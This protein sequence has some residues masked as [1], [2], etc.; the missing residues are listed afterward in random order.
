MRQNE[1]KKCDIDAV[2]EQLWAVHSGANGA[3]DRTTNTFD[4]TLCLFMILTS[5]PKFGLLCWNDFQI[6]FIT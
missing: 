2:T 5:V 6:G 1:Q 3:V 4:G